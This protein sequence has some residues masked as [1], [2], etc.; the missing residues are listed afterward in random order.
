[1][2][3]RVNSITGLNDIKG[4]GKVFLPIGLSMDL[5]HLR[6]STIQANYYWHDGQQTV[7]ISWG[8]TFEKFGSK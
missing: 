3:G 1:M 5:A 6:N 7:T 8:G 2:K 4:I